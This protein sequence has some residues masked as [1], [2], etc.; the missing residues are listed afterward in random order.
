MFHIKLVE[1]IETH[2]LCTVTHFYKIVPFMR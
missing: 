2:I 1:Y